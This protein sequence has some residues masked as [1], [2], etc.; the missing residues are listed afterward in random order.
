MIIKL[1]QKIEIS[2]GYQI[3][4]K[5]KK[6]FKTDYGNDQSRIFFLEIKFEIQSDKKRQKDLRNN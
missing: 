3:Y 6:R 2:R 1:I 5:K 4:L